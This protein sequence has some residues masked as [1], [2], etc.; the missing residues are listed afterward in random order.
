M[1]IALILVAVFFQI[2]TNGTF[3]SPRNTTDLVLQ[4]SYI[5]ILA[6]GM[7]FVILTGRIDLSVGTLLA[8]TSA[9]SGVFMIQLGFPM[10]VAIPAILLLGAFFGAWNG[11]WIAYQGIPFFV[12]TLAGMLVYRGLTMVALEGGT[13]S[14]FPPLFNNFA[15]GFI[16]DIFGGA[17]STNITALIICVIVSLVFIFTELRK[18][19]LTKKFEAEVQPLPFMIVKIVLIVGAINLFGFWFSQHR[20]VPIILILLGALIV[21][22][23]LIAN[24]TV[25]GRH[26]YATGGNA[27]AA[28]LNGVKIKRI[29]FFA[30]VNMSVL[31][32]LA[33]MV[34]AARIDAA[35]PRAE[36]GFELQ[37][38]A[39]CFIGGA[40]PTGGIGK[41]TGAVIGALLMG[42][43]SNGLGLLGMGSDIQLAITGLVVLAAVTFDVFTRTK[44][45]KTAKSN[46]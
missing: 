17:G 6:I 9:L 45:T 46:V 31:A 27:K 34:F 1:I 39:A 41:I 12:V 35:S 10:W 29:V 38:I 2:M 42:V 13:L 43:L 20:G 30:Y 22:Y 8:F 21:I 24:S 19:V 37:A 40:A 28:E 11:F 7:M 36:A 15:A 14:G 26:V 16:P 44:I 23:S 18:H 5:V 25:L 4:N 3:F 33:G 32:A